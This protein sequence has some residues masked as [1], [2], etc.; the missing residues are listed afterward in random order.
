MRIGFLASHNGS[1][2]QAIIDNCK[3]GILDAIPAL[4]ISN[5]S[6]SGALARARTEGIPS[7]LLNDKTHPSPGLLDQAILDALREHS[8]EIVVLAGYMKKLGP[9]TLKHFAGAILNIH[10]ALLPKFGGKGM[11]GIRV[12]EAVLAADEKET[13]VTVHLVD[14]QYDTGKI[15]AQA[16]VP[17][18]PHD[19]PEILA[20]RVLKQEHRLYTEVLQKIASG[21]ITIPG[22]RRPAK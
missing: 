21:E 1:N 6:D 12:H 4:V 11:Y 3:A 9:K 14:E 8:V 15:V 19:T 17:V 13:G 16:R 18:M 22:Y 5:N 2:M 20:A 10:P 7:C